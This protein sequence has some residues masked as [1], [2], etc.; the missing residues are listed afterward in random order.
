MLRRPSLTRGLAVFSALLLLAAAGCSSSSSDPG[1]QSASEGIE[2]K[3]GQFSWTAA[4]LQTEIIRQLA[5]EHPDLGVSTVT[6]VQVDPATGWV[7][8]QRGD[9]DLLTE[10]NLP[11][12][13]TFADKAAAEVNLVSETY[14]GATQGWFVPKYLVDGANAPAAGLKSID[15]LNDYADKVGGTLYDADPGWVTTQQNTKRIEGYGLSLEHKTSSEAALIAQ[16]KRSYDKQEPILLYFYHPHWLF[17]AYDLV[18][19]EEPNPYR[20]GCFTG[21]DNTCAIPTLAAWIGARKDLEQRAPKFY[22]ALGKIEIPLTDIESMLDQVD[23][24]KK[25]PED[26]AEQW[27]TDHQ[28]EIDTWLS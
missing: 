14:G 5:E 22:A 17:E 18:Q 19:L 20:E 3:A 26:V 13:Q 27:I 8:L 12:Q 16:L 11:N 28:S 25:K 7:G 15:Q 9:L 6:S 24:Q 4:E 1:E 10:V 21:D 23:Q 2:I